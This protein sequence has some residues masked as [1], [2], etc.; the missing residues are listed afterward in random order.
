MSY[1]QDGSSEGIF[2]Q[3]FAATGS[4]VGTEF[5]VNTSTAGSQ[6]KPAIA[7]GVAGNFVVTWD[8]YT[9]TGGI[10]HMGQRFGGLS[11]GPSEVD[12][13]GN[14]VLEPGETV[15]Y[16]STWRNQTGSTQ[17]FQGTASNLTG[18]GAPTNPSYTIVD[19]AADYGTV[20]NGATGSCLT[21]GNCFAFSIGTPSV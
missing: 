16:A 14:R 8:A 10:E 2:G 11:T 20:P 15:V 6:F 3:R 21:T 19:A 4:P 18:P 7:S 9:G 1:A 12:Q 17:T 13:G 5:R